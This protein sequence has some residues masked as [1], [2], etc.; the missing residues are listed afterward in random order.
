MAKRKRA[1][2]DAHSVKGLRR[3]LAL[4]QEE[5]A[6]ELGV[7]QQTVSEWETGAYRPRGASERVLSMV[8]EQAGFVWGVAPAM[9]AADAGQQEADGEEQA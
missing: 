6:G 8:A 9:P 4:T 5:L 2:W 1:G 7:R 3:H